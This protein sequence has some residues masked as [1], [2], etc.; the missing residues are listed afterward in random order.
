M[1]L[2]PQEFGAALVL[3]ILFVFVRAIQRVHVVE[4][5]LLLQGERFGEGVRGVR[6]CLGGLGQLFFV[7]FQIVF[8]TPGVVLD[9]GGHEPAGK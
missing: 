4:D 2:A 5:E 3:V 1:R 7:S 6:K 8:G 9:D